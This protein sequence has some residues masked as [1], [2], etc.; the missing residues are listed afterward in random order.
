MVKPNKIQFQFEPGMKL[1]AAS[2]Q[3]KIMTIA[4]P[5]N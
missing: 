3:L 5:A 1:S 4:N 2:Y